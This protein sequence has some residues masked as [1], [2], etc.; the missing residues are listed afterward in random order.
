MPYAERTIAIF[1]DRLQAVS[2]GRIIV[3]FV[4]VLICFMW[5]ARALF[6]ELVSCCL[7]GGAQYFFVGQVFMLS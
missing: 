1:G 2:E 3:N 7:T 5:G 6:F 4:L